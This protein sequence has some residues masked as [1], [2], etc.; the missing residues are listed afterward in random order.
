[1][2]ILVENEC[3]SGLNAQRLNLAL[4]TT[5]LENAYTCQFS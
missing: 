1:M 4:L 5:V 3:L 2:K